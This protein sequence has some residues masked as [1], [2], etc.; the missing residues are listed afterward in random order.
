MKKSI[1]L[2]SGSP[3]RRELLT[4][5]FDEFEV[6]VSDCEETV[7]SQDPEKVTEELA[8]QKAEAVAGSLSLR[9]DP[10]IV[11]GAIQLSVLM[12]KFLANR[13]TSSRLWICFIC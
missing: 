1:I 6:I 8:L 7:T 4:M 9:K 11:I 13:L 12:G 10:V 2:A 3:R 5:L